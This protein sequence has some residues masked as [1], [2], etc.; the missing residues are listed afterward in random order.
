MFSFRAITF[1]KNLDRRVSLIGRIALEMLH[2]KK[3]VTAVAML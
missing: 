3:K 2:L 1:K